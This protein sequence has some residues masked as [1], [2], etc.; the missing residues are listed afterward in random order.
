MY[1]ENCVWGGESMR[2]L[3][4]P[5]VTS[6]EITHWAFVGTRVY[7]KCVLCHNVGVFDGLIILGQGNVRGESK[8]E[9]EDEIGQGW[10]E[11]TL[12]VGILNKEG[13]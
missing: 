3:S 10:V 9:G 8:W 2:E 7:E 6:L 12:V 13:W 1:G 11:S 4:H 5:F